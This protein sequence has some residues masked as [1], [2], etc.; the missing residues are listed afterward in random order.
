M[1]PT[2]GA[3][4][5]TAMHDAV[6]LANWINTIEIASVPN[7]ETIF[8]EY[9]SERHPAA[10]DAFGASQLFSRILGKVKT[11]CHFTFCVVDSFSLKLTV[12]MF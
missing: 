11:H 4:A 6:T 10:K 8:K 9:Q 3:G 2:G 5:L 7:L 1:N 12:V